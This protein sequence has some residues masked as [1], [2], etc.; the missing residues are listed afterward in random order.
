MKFNYLIIL[1]LSLYS[2]TPIPQ[3]SSNSSSNPK[4]LQLIDKAYEPQIR[5][6]LLYPAGSPQLPPAIQL[7]KWNL[8]L[9]FDDL[10]TQNDTYYARIEH[11][12]QDWTR[13]SL[14]DLDYMSTYNEFPINDFEFSV[15]THVPYIHYWMTLPPVKLPGNYV[16][17][18]YRGGNKEDIVLTR[19]FMVFDPMI[20]F[21]DM[22]NLV[23]ASNIASI[24]Q[25]LNFTLNYKNVEILNP[26]TDVHVYLRQNQRWDNMAA[27]VKPSFVREIEK[28][29]E[30]RFFDE[31]QMFRGGNEFRFFDLRSLNYPGRNV[32]SIDR[33]VQPY[34]AFI[35]PDKTR[36]G[37]AYAQYNDF[38]GGFKLDNYD[39]R[40]L[41]FSNYVNVNFT[42]NS[43]PVNGDVYVAGA[44]NYWAL[45]DS[46]KMEYDSAKGQ[47]KLRTL[48][49]QGWYDYQYQVKSATLPS[50]YFEGSHFE[51]ENFYEIFVYYRA[52]RPSADMLIGY[53][54]LVRNRR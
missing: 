38:N 12:N 28:E 48:I 41:A 25:Q 9:Q 24:S 6:I 39:Y 17:T 14:Q 53:Q 50:D 42:L 2:C 47:Y 34:E 23:G 44:F 40:S 15:D 54:M 30:Y 1:F 5:T 27:D 18:V 29:L 31:S 26:L 49:K 20:T 37:Q 13:S 21:K 45:N 35:E 10:V 3:S 19:R 11:C 22:N 8:I 33:T 52:L 16:I 7:G 32:L 46:N 36:R 43:G 51:S 4:A